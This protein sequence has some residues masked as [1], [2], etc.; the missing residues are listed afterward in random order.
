MNHELPIGA[1]VIVPPGDNEHIMQAAIAAVQM[2]ANRRRD[3]RYYEQAVATHPSWLHAGVMKTPWW[4]DLWQKHWRKLRNAWH[5][6]RTQFIDWQWV[7]DNAPTWFGQ[8]IHANAR[9][10]LGMRI[11]AVDRVTKIAKLSDQQH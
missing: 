11:S 7:I 8:R 6:I 10:R 4:K 3:T 5:L 9:S 2:H 1:Q